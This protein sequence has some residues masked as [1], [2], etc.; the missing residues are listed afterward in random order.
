MMAS[1]SVS[2]LR[3]LD[4][5]VATLKTYHADLSSSIELQGELIRC[6]LTSPRAPLVQ[7]FPLTRD[8]LAARVID[9]I[10]LLHDQTISI[11]VPFASDLFDRLLDLLRWHGELEDKPRLERIAAELAG[12]RLDRERLFSEG[13]VQHDDHVAEIALRA[14]VAFNLLG[15]LARQS[16][17][18]VLQAYAQRLVPLLKPVST[19]A[20]TGDGNAPP[21]TRGYCPVCGAWPILGELRADQPSGPGLNRQAES[22]ASTRD[23]QPDVEA[24][25]WF[26]C[27]ACGCDWRA[28]REVCP[29]CGQ[30]PQACP[31]GLTALFFE[32][33]ALAPFFDLRIC[34]HCNTYL[35]V[36]HTLEPL[37]SELLILDDAASRHLDLIAAERGY[38]RPHGSGFRIELGLPD[39]EWLDEP[40]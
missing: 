22:L 1:R 26:R 9:G 21:W 4:E 27:G 36:R 39:D 13:F 32:S 2:V 10:P 33:E 12:G 5:R 8:Q 20:G 19:S 7:P 11:D 14:S 40:E 25:L 3:L 37:V 15:M 35:K 6:A 28:R 17:A 23:M 29:F 30:S 34:E 16:V 38:Q 24:R 18:P 31:G